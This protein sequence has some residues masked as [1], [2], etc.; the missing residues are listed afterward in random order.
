MLRSMPTLLLAFSCGILAPGVDP[1]IAAV[2]S[3][4]AAAQPATL[5][6]CQEMLRNGKYQECLTATTQAI[7]N[8][9]Y[10]EEWP[11][12]KIRSELALGKYP[13]A[14]ETVK[15]GLE[16]YAWSVRLRMLEFDIAFANGLPD[17]AA[18]AL[19]EIERLVSSASWRYTDA[20]D[21]VA[22]G[23]AALALGA[24]ARDVQEGFFERARRNFKTHP[25]GFLAA[26]E[27]A[28]AKGDFQLAAEI[29]RPAEKT[30]P[31]DPEIL[32]ALSTALRGSDR[33]A[34]VE[35]MKKSLEINPNFSPALQQ[36][37]E[38]QIDGEE[39][40][41]AEQIL[42]QIFSVNPHSPEAHALQ[43]VIH[44]LRNDSEAEQASHD[45]AI[46]FSLK[47]ARVEHLIGRKL[48]QKYRFTEGAAYQRKSLEAD[49]DF[50]EAR[51]QLAQ[52]L[53]RLGDETSGWE[54]ADQ[55]HKKDGY[56][57][58]LFNLLQ[59]KG[60]LDKFRTLESER[61]HVRMEAREAA[62]Y[63]SQVL[64]L[65]EK[66]HVELSSR[67]QFVP[68]GPIVVE[69]FPRADDFAVRTFGMPDVS[70]FLGVC[71]GKVI[72]ANSPATR[73]EN[74]SNWESILW[75]EFCHVIT[76]QMTDNRI[77]RW[78]SEGI[79]VYEE[80]RLDSR[81]GQRMNADFRDRV[82]D[83]KVTPV[84]KLS[85]A[86]LTAGSGE[87][88]N[89]AYYESSMVVEH[90]VAE[91]GME[92][93]T[94][95]LNDLKT[96]LSVNDAL[97]RNTNGLEP[98]EAS[99]AEFLKAQARLYAPEA[100]FDLEEL[101]QVG[102][103]G[104][105]GDLGLEEFVKTHPKN[106]PAG[107]S[108]AAKWIN[109]KR[110]DAAEL[111][112]ESLISLVPEDGSTNGPRVLLAGI[113]RQTSRSDKEEL[114]L[115]EHLKRN[116]DDLP[117]VLR[118]QELF[119]NR[120]EFAMAAKLGHDVLA[121]DPFQPDA[122]IRMASA[123]EQAGDQ[124]AAARAL[125]SLLQLQPDDAARLHFRIARLVKDAEPDRAKRHVLYSLEIAPRYREALQ[126]LLSLQP[127]ADAAVQ[128]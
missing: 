33:P 68:E 112:L 62:V 125:E 20:D 88:L 94:A 107:L 95:V 14:A 86:F 80:R 61:F 6:E 84:G 105:R 63:G 108:L 81:W 15:S 123:A 104:R 82:L 73:R 71:F 128:N 16:R 21:L 56:N 47:N 60:S 41:T 18:S 79:S 114:I 77:P 67:Y 31:A 8:R 7:A 57:T 23:K 76:L 38:D 52:D 99:F 87:D 96:G 42:Q 17:Q 74:P 103:A 116:A 69:I 58:T 102:A 75:H 101:E 12:L 11:I 9:S 46:R 64:A 13:E 59:L 78:L 89:F 85:S 29:L 25:D 28:N 34:S 49:P 50:Q 43:A 4:Q 113:Y 51:I 65:L 3:P 24:D 1:L 98:L 22:L 32:F 120:G 37:A 122:I 119:F 121:I 111:L 53:L 91:F 45:A 117:A 36:L 127:A 40:A 100:E 70:G 30:F 19:V 55:A 83:G 2:V 90:L 26:G 27:L 66:A 44:H 54:L 92:A 109:E 110:L 118:L 106:F 5:A 93:L 115:A 126:L 35:L 48:S 124:T 10:G 72:T 97:A 39:Y